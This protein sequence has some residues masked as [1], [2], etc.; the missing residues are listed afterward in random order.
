MREIHATTAGPWRATH[1]REVP[2][3]LAG[4]KPRWWVAGGWALDLFLGK[5]SRAHKVLDIGILRRD[6]P[7]VV[8]ELSGFEF[9]EAKDGRLFRLEGMPRATVNSLWG[10]PF[11]SQQ[12]VLELLLDEADQGEWIFRRDRNIRYPLDL[13]VQYDL[14]PVHRWLRRL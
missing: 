5:Q 1:P 11:G 7:D 4:V 9:F 2:A 12:W 14:D 3:Y 8:A 10:R 6:A 13:L